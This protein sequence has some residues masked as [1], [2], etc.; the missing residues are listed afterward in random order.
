MGS[1]APG[2]WPDGAGGNEFRKRIDYMLREITKLHSAQGGALT[3]NIGRISLESKAPPL[4]VNARTL[5]GPS[6]KEQRNLTT[7]ECLLDRK[8]RMVAAPVGPPGA[9]ERTESVAMEKDGTKRAI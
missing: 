8:N 4:P 2:G 5:E 9:G 7:N 6:Q 1:G 3:P